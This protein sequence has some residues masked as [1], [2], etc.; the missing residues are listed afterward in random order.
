[1][2]ENRIF[3]NDYMRLEIKDGILYGLYKKGTVDLEL[4]KKI[5]QNRLDFTGNKSVPMLFK[6]EGLKGIE[7]EVRHYLNSDIGIKGVSAGAIVT[8]SAFEAHL[9]NFFIKITLINPRIPTKVFKKETDA[10]QW[11]KEYI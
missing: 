11:L 2:L 4:A 5:V 6:Q 3:E 9:A 10:I 1:M 7:R 8:K